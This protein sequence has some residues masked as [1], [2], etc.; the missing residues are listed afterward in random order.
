MGYISVKKAARKHNMPHDQVLEL[1]NKNKIKIIELDGGMAVE[2]DALNQVLEKVPNRKMTIEVFADK[3]GVHYSTVLKY[4]KEGK[5]K[6]TEDEEGRK[7]IP[8]SELKKVAAIASR[9][10]P[11]FYYYHGNYIHKV[12][13]DATVHKILS[14]AADNDPAKIETLATELF[15]DAVLNM[16]RKRR[17]LA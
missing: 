1:I 9:K 3:V 10:S 12:K 17:A 7:M 14:E 11:S 8:A 6:F 4:I 2:E 15:K 5:L 13:L 16:P